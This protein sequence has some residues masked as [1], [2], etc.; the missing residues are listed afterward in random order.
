MVTGA[1]FTSIVEVSPRSIGGLAIGTTIFRLPFVFS[2]TLVDLTE[3]ARTKAMSALT[4]VKLAD[5]FV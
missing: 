4:E 5:Q 1:E 2:E 3:L